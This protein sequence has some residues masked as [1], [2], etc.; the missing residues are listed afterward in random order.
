[1]WEMYKFTLNP[2]EMMEIFHIDKIFANKFFIEGSSTNENSKGRDNFGFKASGK[3]A[4]FDIDVKM[5]SDN[6][7]KIV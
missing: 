3:Q 4:R 2:H 7:M 1:M 6:V 5:V